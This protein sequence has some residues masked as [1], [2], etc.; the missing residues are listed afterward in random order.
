MSQI[1]DAVLLVV[2]EFL[3]ADTL[4]T[5][6]DVSNKVKE[7]LPH[8]RHRDV[9]DEVR[10]L[11]DSEIEPSCYASTPITVTLADG[12]TQAQALLY[13]PLADSWDL[14]NKYDVQQRA[15]V[16]AKVA[17]AGTPVPVVS[18]NGTSATVSTDGTVTVN[19]TPTASVLVAPA[20]LP[21]KS[22]WE[23]LFDNNDSL[24]PRKS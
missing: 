19:K 5:A 15:K 6:L 21:A 11:F 1:A 4:F 10:S 12:C 24:F 7:S 2:R 8:A 14:D 16:S 3:K 20:P 22:A 13:H 18:G 9:R 23:N 17:A